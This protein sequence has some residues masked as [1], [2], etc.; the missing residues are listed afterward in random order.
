MFFDYLINLLPTK[1]TFQCTSKIN[2]LYLRKKTKYQYS[3]ESMLMNRQQTIQ[4]IHDYMA[5]QPVIKA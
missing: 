3:L 4:A 5:S 2:L 1:E